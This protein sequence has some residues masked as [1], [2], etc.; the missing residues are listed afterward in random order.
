M[1]S[2]SCCPS[3]VLLAIFARERRQR[4]EQEEELNVA[5]RRT[6]LLLGDI[7]ESDDAYTGSHSRGVV[8]LVTEV[9]DVLAAVGRRAHAGRVHGP[10]ARRR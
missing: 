2:C 6:M 5:Y 7:I 8:E 3:T 10:P 1:R 4:L 9:A